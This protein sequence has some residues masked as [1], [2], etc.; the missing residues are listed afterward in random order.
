MKPKVLSR[1]KSNTGIKKV[2]IK[3]TNNFEY[4]ISGMMKR[5][6]TLKYSV[7]PKMGINKG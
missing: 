5:G 3:T 1:K 7:T 6:V 2:R 4:I